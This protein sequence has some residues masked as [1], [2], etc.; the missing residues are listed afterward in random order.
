[1]IVIGLTGS[2][3]TGKS[4]VAGMFRKKGAV[5]L[6]ADKTAHA[7]IGKNGKCAKAVIKTFGTNNRRKLAAIVFNDARDL[8]K[9]T[10]I[11]HPAVSK[12]FGKAIND[13]RKGGKVKA[14]VMDVPLLFEAGMDRL[15]D[16]TLTVKA[17]RK[18]Q[19]VRAA[20]RFKITPAQVHKRIKNQMPLSKKI[21]LSDII[22]DNRGSLADTQKQ[23]NAIWNKLNKRYT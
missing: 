3:G 6:D 13:Y 21:S 18:E 17:G 5:V 14:V 16:V 8:N 1:M 2:F 15:A 20:R 12:E 10:R 7:L 23:V 11:V 9:L 19:I 4:T 22:I